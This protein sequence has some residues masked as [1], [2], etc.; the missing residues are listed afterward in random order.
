MKKLLITIVALLSFSAHA[1]E[2]TDDIRYDTK[3]IAN[4]ATGGAIG[5]AATTVD[6]LA[7]FNLAQST[8]GQTVTLPNPTDARANKVV[9]LTNVGAV[10]FIAY[11][12]TVQPTQSTQVVWSGTAWKGA[13]AMPT[14]SLSH[15]FSAV[16]ATTLPDGT[17]DLTE[18]I[19]RNGLVGLNADAN[20]TLHINSTT[21]NDSGLRLEQAKQGVTQS[22]ANI[23]S[24]A[25]GIDTTGKVVVTN[26]TGSADTRAVDSQPQAYQNGS[27]NEFKQASV[28]SMGAITPATG[29]YVGLQTFRRYGLNGDF[30]GGQVRQE[31]TTDDGRTYYRMSTSATAWGNWA[32]VPTGRPAMQPRFSS[33]ATTKISLAGEVRWAGFYHVMTAGT[34]PAEPG[35]HF[36]IDMPADGFAV[37]VAGGGTRAVVA[38]TVGSSVDTGGILLNAWETLYYKH[39]YGQNQA[40]VP[41]NLLIVS[42]TTNTAALSLFLET[43]DWIKVASRDDASVFTLGTGDVVGLGSQTGR[44][45]NITSANWAAMKQ[46]VHGEGYFFSPAGNTAVPTAFGFT[47]S[48]RWIDGGSTP[49]V[50]QTGY[51]DANPAQRVAGTAVRGV[52][53]AANRAWRLMT[54]AEKPEWFGGAL[55]GA[56]AISATTSTVVD[57]NDNETLYCAPNLESGSAQCQWIVAGYA[58]FVTT[59]EHWLPVVSKQTTGA[60]S[61][62]QILLGGV[63]GTLKAGDAL[64]HGGGWEQAV[65]KLHRSNGITHKGTK[66]ARWSQAGFFSGTSANGLL[67]S[68]EAILVSWDDNTLIYGISDGY[69][70][71]GNQYTYINIPASG[72]AIP[73]VMPNSNITRV[74]QTIGG[75]R[76]IPLGVWE[77]LY[78]IPPAYTGGNIS[79]VGD[80]VICYY[81]SNCALPAGSVLIA[82]REGAAANPIGNT[83]NKNRILFADKTYFQPGFTLAVGT[84]T[85]FDHS[86][87]SAEWR[88]VTVAGSTPPAGTAALPAVAGVIGNYGAPYTMQYRQISLDDDPRGYVEIKGLIQLNGNVAANSDLAFIPS[89]TPYGEPI[90]M[91]QLVASTH[92]DSMPIPVSIRFFPATVGGQQGMQMRVIANSMNALN[93]LLSLGT[94]G[95][96]GAASIPQWLSCDNVR[97]PLN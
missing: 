82:K 50:N 28:I 20:T 10:P 86:H 77:A 69:V 63:R 31:A 85:L 90:V 5:T 15:W 52:N 54:A 84:P 21:A 94:N 47:G 56:L 9:L 91:C 92:S 96:A 45:G 88:N 3:P 43:E 41:A 25:L 57:L 37:P 22:V 55:R 68:G 29:T 17:A 75:R 19:R 62:M 58:G 73:V 32:R 60:N 83:I 81:N 13:A 89:A 44:G 27:Y 78:Q 30:S 59:P 51:I 64:F 53:G 26:A 4:L 76:F 6:V 65:D 33:Q 48:I 18:N 40:F 36:R 49:N 24:V 34:N 16:G 66:H 74:V 11:G 61:T 93:P 67:G 72:T 95:N 1:L 12:V 35:G 7:S 2:V 23:T 80:F 97:I 39:P 46:R 70:S 71:W 38:A 14:P 42:Y 79:L 8:A 87:W